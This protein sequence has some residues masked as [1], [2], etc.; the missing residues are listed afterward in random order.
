MSPIHPHAVAIDVDST[1]HVAA[2][3][4]LVIPRRFFELSLPVLARPRWIGRL[5]HPAFIIDN[6][7]YQE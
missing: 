1:L 7:F 2:A 5:P 6:R 3:I 4:R